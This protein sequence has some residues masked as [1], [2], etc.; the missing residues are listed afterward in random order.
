MS[1]AT[2]RELTIQLRRFANDIECDE[3]PHWLINHAVK[4]MSATLAVWIGFMAQK[5]KD[6][7]ESA[8]PPFRCGYCADGGVAKGFDT[9]RELT[10][11]AKRDHRDADA[12]AALASMRRGQLV[13]VK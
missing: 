7:T 9:L 13:A 1:T 2:A 6:A 11:H 5:K 12:S 3:L 10:W 4:H 8:L